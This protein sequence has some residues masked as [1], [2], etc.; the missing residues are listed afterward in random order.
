M[1]PSQPA[2]DL[3]AAVRQLATAAQPL[4]DADLGQPYRWGAHQE[5]ARFALLGSM[6]EL[7]AL[8]VRLAA[9][10]RRAGPPLTRAQHALGQYHAAY[11]DLEAVMLG[12]TAEAYDASPAPG[13]W[14]LRYV[15]SHMVGAERNF[16]ALVHYGIRR[17]REGDGLDPALPEGE[18]NRLFGPFDE[19]AAIMETGSPE[20]MTERHRLHHDRTLAELAGATD[21]ELE[22]PSLWWEGEAYTLEY[23][24]HRFDAHLRQHTAQVEKTL[25]QIG[26]PANEARRLIRQLYAALAEAEA[27]IIGAP[28]TAPEARAGL[29][30]ALAQRSEGLAAAAG[31]ARAFIAAVQAGDR[32]RVDGL[33][34]EDAAL[35]NASDQNGV[36][37]VRVAAYYNEP[38]VAEYLAGAGAELEIWD[39]VALGRLAAVEE[40]ERDWGGYILNEYSRDGYTPLQLACFFGREDIARWLVAKG[41]GLAAVS[42]NRMA[43]QPL[44][45]AAAGNHLGIVRL[46]LDA[47][48]DPNAIQSDSFRP[49]HSAAQ[50]GNAAMVAL[51]LERGADPSLSDDRGR[52][53]RALAEA[54][55]H[56][57]VVALLAE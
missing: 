19:F 7:R 30:A 31:R 5:G 44:H 52:T 6:H 20:A 2:L 16:F 4:S 37:A 47:G 8:A 54:Q 53:P 26:R 45:A 49:L 38:E 34:A 22:G 10:R 40:A 13:E 48:A 43:I 55:G 25:D 27:A 32:A 57:D 21:E 35:V 3:A 17:Q 50:N 23:R 29:A 14:P 28:G 33:L 11:R 12:V 51:L 18:A 36:P 9:E 42:R 56:A 46:L 15:Y 39:A 1:T 24:L 41:A